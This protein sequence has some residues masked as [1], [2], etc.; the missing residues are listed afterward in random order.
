MRVIAEALQKPDS[1]TE[2]EGALRKVKAMGQLPEYQ[3]GFKQFKRFMAEMNDS[4][5][6][7]FEE[8]A[9][10][11][12]TVE[13]DLPLEIV[14]ERNGENIISI[15]VKGGPFS[16]KIQN[17]KPG[18]FDVKLKTGRLLWQG[19]LTDQDLIW[20]TA[21]PEKD[22][23]IAADTGDRAEH[24][25]REITL[26]EGDLIMRVIPELESGCIELGK[27]I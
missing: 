16:E 13:K 22:L 24:I 26:L 6:K 20:T 25:T 12:D 11:K 19:V 7:H 17:I 9:D 27:R 1:K 2:I 5:K 15:P 3:L 14:I 23:A 10:M 18:Q 4:V 8:P 21:F